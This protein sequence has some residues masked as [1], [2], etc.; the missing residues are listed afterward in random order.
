MVGTW[1]EPEGTSKEAPIQI[2]GTSRQITI[3][4]G[5]IYIY[6]HT[7]YI[8]I[9]TLHIYIYIYYTYMYIYICN[10]I[11]NNSLCNP[12]QIPV[13]TTVKTTTNPSFSQV[14]L[15]VFPLFC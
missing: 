11:L 8:Y 10:P 5:Y 1:L 9:Y 15:W 4:V 7:I 13:S 6:I 2:P 3:S 12:F 14:F